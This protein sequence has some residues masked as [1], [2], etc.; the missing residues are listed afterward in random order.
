MRETAFIAHDDGAF[1]AVRD[2][3]QI[4]PQRDQMGGE[5]RLN[6]KKVFQCA[7]TAEY[8]AL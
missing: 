2:A 4:S 7:R 1:A 3:P 8:L 5:A 6:G